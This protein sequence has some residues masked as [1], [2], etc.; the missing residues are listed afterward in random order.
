MKGLKILILGFVAAVSSA[1]CMRWDYGEPEDMVSAPEGLFVLNE[2]NF[3]YGNATLSYY[4]PA[5]DVVENEVFARANGFKLGDVAQSMTMYG[6]SGWLVVNNSHVIFEID[7]DTFREKGR[8]TGL[9]SPRYMHF[10]S[11]TKAYV[12]QIWE[13]RIFVVNP[14]EYA[15]TGYIEIPGMDR[16]DGSTEMMVQIGDYVYVNC[17]SYWNLLV[18]IDTRTDRVTD[19]MEVG[20]QPRT[21]VA[22]CMGRLW[23]LCDG[24][25]AGSPYAYENP[26]LVC[27]D[28]ESMTV[29]RQFEFAL[30]TKATTV[31]VN[32]SRDRLYWI[33]DDVWTMPVTATELPAEPLIA[34]AGTIYYGLTVDPV[35][36][37][38][39]V[40]DAIDYQQQGVVYRYGADGGYKSR[41]YV[42]ITPA[43]FCWKE[44]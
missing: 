4:D 36:G 10:V 35:E 21:M 7:P 28:P 15:V 37:D 24:G 27:V 44:R 34:A 1:G 2:G 13:N 26:T 40:A 11:D 9:T 3:Q 8:I 41:F 32:G 25:Y 31:A 12:T 18:K 39:Y 22:D 16:R 38:I 43:S 5:T 6:G 42:G 33:C 19:V 17:Y 23:V 14:A 29:V 30:G 20:I